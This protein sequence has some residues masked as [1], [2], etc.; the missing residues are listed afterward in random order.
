M[1]ENKAE[2][3]FCLT[4]DYDKKSPHPENVFTGIAKMIEAFQ[5][6]DEQLIGCVDNSLKPVLLLQ[7][8]ERGSIKTWLQNQL[9][10]MPDEV[11]QSG[12][13]KQIIGKYL[14]DA[15]YFVLGKISDVDKIEDAE[16]VEGIEEGI[17]KIAKETGVNKLNCYSKPP[18][19]KLLGSINGVSNAFKEF[20][21]NDVIKVSNATGQTMTLNKSFQLSN[22][23]IADFC[24]GQ[25]LEN[26]N[27]AILKVKMPDFLGN[28]QWILKYGGKSLEC[29]FLDA[30]WLKKYRA[31]IVTIKPGDSLMVSLHIIS[32]Y[33]N[34]HN[35]MTDKYEILKVQKVISEP[36]DQEML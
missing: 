33:D 17:L 21:E 1:N 8:V 9:Q 29:K 14:V 36:V 26:T 19:D 34:N 35:L 3:C 12:D 5:K 25:I 30:E 13:L 23:D 11:L 20:R 28:A 18:R 31:G 4:I 24:A 15:K 10:S 27:V 22:E 32:T 6:M 7:D 2:V 16:Y